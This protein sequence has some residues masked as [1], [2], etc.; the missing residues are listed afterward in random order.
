MLSL[1]SIFDELQPFYLQPSIFTNLR[2]MAKKEG[3]TAVIQNDDVI[4]I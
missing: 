2:K 3:K 1:F 4:M